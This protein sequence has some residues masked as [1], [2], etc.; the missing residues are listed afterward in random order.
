[1]LSIN[2]DNIIDSS[3][4]L[5]LKDELLSKKLLLDFTLSKLKL[6]RVILFKNSSLVYLE[7]IITSS[8]I[9][10]DILELFNFGLICLSSSI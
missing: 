6:F 8:S 1:M 5:L 7:I 9:Y 10:S 2:S 3:I 4:I